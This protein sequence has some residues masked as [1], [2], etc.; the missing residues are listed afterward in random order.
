MGSS[1]RLSAA[2]Q[3]S[4]ITAGDECDARKITLCFP[5][6]VPPLTRYVSRWCHLFLFILQEQALRGKS[7]HSAFYLFCK[8]FRSQLDSL[9]LSNFLYF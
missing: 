5:L 1:A 3:N 8:L 6:S 2:G 9:L 7:L 4:H